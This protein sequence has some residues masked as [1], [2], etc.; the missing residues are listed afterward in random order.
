M[1]KQTTGYNKYPNP[2]WMDDDLSHLDL[3]DGRRPSSPY[4]SEPPHGSHFIASARSRRVAR[5]KMINR[6]RDWLLAF[7]LAAIA[8]ACIISFATL[9]VWWIA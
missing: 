3:F 5:R 2:H 8:W 1:P 4:P 7:L 9:V 6:L